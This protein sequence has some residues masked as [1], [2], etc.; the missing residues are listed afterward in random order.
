MP[1]IPPSEELR[2]AMEAYVADMGG[3][4]RV[5]A[6]HGICRTSLWRFL[7]TG[8]AMP[9]NLDRYRRALAKH[10][11]EHEPRAS[12]TITEQDIA[13][14]LRVIK[15]LERLARQSTESTRTRG[16][17]DVRHDGGSDR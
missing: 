13:S 17:G 9:E 7:R 8:K 12:E 15:H 2:T 1:R 16:Y 14:F 3:R 11:A 4:S 10:K 6:K 5:A